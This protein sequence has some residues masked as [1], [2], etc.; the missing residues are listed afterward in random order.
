[1]ESKNLWQLISFYLS[2][3]LALLRHLVLHILTLNQSP[4]IIKFMDLILSVYFRLCNL[5]P[6][7]VDLDDQT[8]IHF[9]VTNHR[10]F[11]R[12]SLVMIHGYGGNPL[13]QFVYQVG[14]LSRRFNLYIPDL[15][16]FGKSHSKSPF[17]SEFFQAKC[18]SD[19]LKRIGVDRFSVYAI[20]YGGFVAYRMAEIRPDAVEKVAIVSSGLFYTDEQR[21][22]QLRTIG[23]HP[24]EILVP[25]KPDDLRLLVNL[26]TFKQSTLNWVPDFLLRQFITLMYDH[27]RKE[28]IELADYLVQ[29]KA[30]PNLHVLT[31]ETLI[32]WGDQDKVFPLE[33]AYNLQRHL[34]KNSRLEIIKNVGHAANLES[35]DE[36]NK[37]IFSF[38]I[39][40][41]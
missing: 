4:F 6:C 1:M 27:C 31:Q 33:L 18:L 34:G 40:C 22:Q 7:A 35:P 23:R 28:K 5:S 20:S 3:T 15:L 37:L 32:I 30:D 41:S 16:F 17:R 11:D 36:L 38:V 12:P 21:D 25:K 13:W 24:S 26:S 14:P 19:G 39:G 10:R 29:K 8:T 2:T 9:W